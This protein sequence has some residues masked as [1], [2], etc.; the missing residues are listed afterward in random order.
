MTE[1]IKSLKYEIRL[2]DFKHDSFGTAMDWLGAIADHL[3]ESGLQ[4]SVPGSWGYYAPFGVADDHKERYSFEVVAE[5]FPINEEMPLGEI[6]A[7][8][9]ELIEVGN[10]LDRL[11]DI[12]KANGTDY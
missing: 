7:A 11:I 10:L 9:S 8:E 3:T 5:L 2:D 12:H 4:S 6:I 1:R